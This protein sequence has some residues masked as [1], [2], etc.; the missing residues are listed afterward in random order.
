MTDDSK[1]ALAEHP[2]GTEEG[3]KKPASAPGNLELFPLP[4]EASETGKKFVRPH[5]KAPRKDEALP[6]VLPE[7]PAGPEGIE[8]A[9][10]EAVEVGDEMPGTS[11]L[12][13]TRRIVGG[14]A[15]I[16]IL[17]LLG[18]VQLA[19]GAVLLELRFPPGAFMGVAGFLVLASLI[20]LVLVPFVWGT[21]PGLALVDLRIQAPDGGSPTLGAAFLRFTGFLLTLAL[22]GVPMLVA[23]FDKEGRTLADLLSRTSVAPLHPEPMAPPGTEAG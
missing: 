10:E 6:A 2:I 1:D 22:G 13:F 19:A 7:R 3:P 12:V 18:T 5:K 4:D 14:L 8:D 9:L 21:T 11:R 20:L 23:A 17:V 16:L 15:D